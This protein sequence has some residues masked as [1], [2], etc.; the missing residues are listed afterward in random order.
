MQ[1]LMHDTLRAPTMPSSQGQP[2]EAGTAGP[3]ALAQRCLSDETI[4]AARVSATPN[5][6]KSSQ[7]IF[8]QPKLQ[9]VQR[10]A[11]LVSSRQQPLAKDVTCVGPSK[12]CATGNGLHEMLPH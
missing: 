8:R 10:A 6:T 12:H 3:M 5:I 4:H 1:Q 2:A 11:P 9:V 7:S